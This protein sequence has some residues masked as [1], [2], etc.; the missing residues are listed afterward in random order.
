MKRNEAYYQ[1]VF[2]DFYETH[3]FFKGSYLAREIA[4]FYNHTDSERVKDEF[5]PFSITD[6]IELD[7]NN[8][9]HLWEAKKL[10]SDELLKGKVIGQLMFYDFLF[11]SYP[12]EALRQLLIDAGFEKSIIRSLGDE[13][14]RFET[15]NILVCG[16]EGWEICAGVNPIM[17]SYADLQKR[18]LKQGSPKLNTFHFYEV[19][20]GW[21]LKNIFELSIFYPQKLHKEA[22][23]KYLLRN[24]DFTD[25]L[26]EDEDRRLAFYLEF[27]NKEKGI[28]E[29]DLKLLAEYSRASSDEEFFEKCPVSRS[30]FYQL[31]SMY[32]QSFNSV[33]GSIGED[34]KVYERF[35]EA[36]GRKWFDFK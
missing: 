31:L 22:F 11:R 6:F 14:F 34:K 12:K 8:R 13:A 2:L 15:W 29:E 33:F 32:E 3:P 30:S 28:T 17:W 26:P 1:K 5:M 20:E 16:G 18:Y 36:I 10:H 27:I 35:N 23:S 9:F 19:S 25:T 7:K 4:Q 21:D 24:Y